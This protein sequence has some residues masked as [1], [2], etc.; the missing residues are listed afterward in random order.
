M[1]IHLQILAIVTFGAFL[2]APNIEAM[3]KEEPKYITALIN[4]S[5]SVGEIIIIP[6]RNILIGGRTEKGD[7]TKG[8]Q[9]P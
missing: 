5:P 9:I 8:T 4:K 2:T 6:H 7:G 3:Q 1:K